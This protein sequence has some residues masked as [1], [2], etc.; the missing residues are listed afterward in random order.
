MGRFNCLFL[1][2][3]WYKFSLHPSY[4]RP[5]PSILMIIYA[6]VFSGYEVSGMI[7]LRDLNGAM[8]LDRS[9]DLSV[10]I[11]TC[12]SYDL[13]ALTPVVWKLWRW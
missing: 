4:G 7:L 13:N 11:S 2:L 9:I 5:E 1:Y 6:Y 3:S 8:R 12:T 10:H